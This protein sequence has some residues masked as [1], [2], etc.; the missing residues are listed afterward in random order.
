M[1]IAITVDGM[2][3]DSVLDSR[4]GRARR[5]MLYDTEGGTFDLLDN[6]QNLDAAQGAGIQSAQNVANAGAEALITGHT[7]PKAFAVLQKAKIA[8]YHSEVRPVRDI[9]NAF[10]KGELQR[11]ESADVESHWV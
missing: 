7:G 11:A 6:A 8:V 5:F 1:K 10:K 3:L 2:T 4:F 9:V